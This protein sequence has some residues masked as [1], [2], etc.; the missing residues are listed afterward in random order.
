MAGR[1]SFRRWAIYAICKQL[2]EYGMT[3]G[4]TGVLDRSSARRSFR[5]RL[6]SVEYRHRRPLNRVNARPYRASPPSSADEFKGGSL[7][8]KY[9]TASTVAND[10]TVPEPSKNL[11]VAFYRRLPLPKTSGKLARNIC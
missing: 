7:L 4:P 9:G 2:V 10:A 8:S 5:A 1:W 3:T 11:A 6:F